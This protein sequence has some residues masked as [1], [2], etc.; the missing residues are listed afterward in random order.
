MATAISPT[1]GGEIGKIRTFLLDHEKL[2][3]VLIAAVVLWW[4]YG[5]YAQIRLDHD[6]AALQQQKL[7]VAAQVQQNAALAVQAQKDAVQAA[8]D[9]AALQALSDKIAA[10]N[11]QLVAANTALATA[12]TKQQHT[13]ASLPVPDL[14][15]R[16]AQLAPGT[17][18]T[19]AIGSGNNVAVTPS[20]AL[21]TVQQLE[22]VPVLTQQLA[23]E[24]TLKTND[25]QLIVSQNKS[26]FDLNTEVGGLN[27]SLVGAFKLDTDHQAQCV[28]QIKVV[29]DEA[30]KSKRRWFTAGFILGFIAEHALKL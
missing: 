13:D 20:N 29:K 30:R 23:N 26:I 9:K 3:I 10:Q 14:V 11:Q 19:G 12:L 1:T 17:N 15:N 25:D 22:K 7:V 6:N 8:Q 27:A 2:L 28:D 16:W 18:F 5:K 21:A 4:G 24:T